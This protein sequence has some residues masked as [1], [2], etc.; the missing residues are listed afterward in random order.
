MTTPELTDHSR[1]VTP[2]PPSTPNG[3]SDPY[4]FEYS[5]VILYLL[6]IP[7]G[8]LSFFGFGWILWEIQGPELFVAVFDVTE[9]GDATIVTL[10]LIRLLVP[11]IVA[12]LVAVIVHELIHGAVMRYY[13]KDVTYGVNPAMGAFYT[14][15][16]GQFQG[17]EELGPIALAPLVGIT[18][19]GLLLLFVPIPTVAVTA[20]LVLV[21]N[22]TGAVGDLYFLWR[23]RRL[24]A[25]MLFY[26]VDLR[27]WYVF[28]PL[29]AEKPSEY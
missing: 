28:E 15:A 4:P 29:E 24:P 19:A 2:E 16:F 8:L 17:I 1:D 12:V 13:G 6:S 26:E 11:F 7:L 3:Y 20:Y 27:H 10:D 25:G 9:T 22:A 21:V 23:L 14:A 18:A 5:T